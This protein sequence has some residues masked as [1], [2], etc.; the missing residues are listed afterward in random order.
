[1]IEIINGSKFVSLSEKV[2]SAIVSTEDFEKFNQFG[3]L[4]IIQ[5]YRNEKMNAIWF[6]N[7]NLKVSDGDIV[8]CQTEALELLFKK[9]SNTDVKNLN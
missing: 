4:K 7:E 9:L 5:T 1:M 2:F 3:N 6:Y 8:F